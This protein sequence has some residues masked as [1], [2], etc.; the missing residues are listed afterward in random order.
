MPLPTL[1][2]PGFIVPKKNA[3]DNDKKK[4]RNTTGIDHLMSFFSKRIP[5]FKG[6]LPEI[7]ALCAADKVL[8]LKSG[9][10][11]GKST[12]FVEALYD[13]FFDIMK[14]GI[15]I[16]QPRILTAKDIPFTIV[17]RRKD[18]Q[19]GVNIGFQTGI[20]SI[21]VTKGIIFMT[22]Q[23]LVQQLKT[24]TDE[25]FMNKY[26]V[27]IIDEVHTRDTSI[28][29]VMLFMKKLLMRNYNKSECPIL[30][31]MSAT[32]DPSTYFRY[33]GV[34]LSEYETTH[35]LIEVEGLSHPIEEHWL[36]AD[37]DDYI[38]FASDTAL[39]IHT[40]N[41]A[42]LNDD[43][44]GN[45][46]PMRD[47]L[48][49]AANKSIITKIIIELDKYNKSID[50]TT[51]KE[52]TLSPKGGGNGTLFR[53]IPL[54]PADELYSGTD[55]WS[56]EEVIGAD[57]VTKVTKK[58]YWIIP[59]ILTSAEFK[60]G[61]REYLNLFSPISEIRMKS[62]NGET[63]IPT[64]R[65]IVS[66]N[67]A[68]TGVTIETLKYVIISGWSLTSSFVSHIGM[69]MLGANPITQSETK[70]Q[71]GR[72]GRLAPGHVYYAFTKD[73]Y[74][75]M[76]DLLYPAIIR[77]EPTLSLSDIIIAQTGA[78]IK[79]A[80]MV[81]SEKLR[82]IG[83]LTIYP[84]DAVCQV[85]YFDI[86]HA[87]LLD[88]PS[89]D[90]LIYSLEKLHILGFIDHNNNTTMTGLLASAFRK[91]KIENIKMILSGYHYG[92][93]IMDLI[94]ITAFLELKT[95]D[96]HILKRKTYVPQNIFIGGGQTPEEKKQ[97]KKTY[98]YNKLLIQ[99][100]CI[101]FIFIWDAFLQVIGEFSLKD[102]SEENSKEKPM[103]I[104]GDALPP[105]LKIAKWCN[106]SNLN[107]GN[108]LNVAEKIDEIREN[109]INAGLNPFI[110]GIGLPM[111]EYNLRKIITGNISDGVSEISKIKNCIYEGYKLNMCTWNTFINQYMLN[112]KH[113]PIEIDNPLIKLLPAEGHIK[114]L[115]PKKI[116]V[117]DLI[118]KSDPMAGGKYLFQ[119]TGA[120]SVMDGFVS[121]DNGFM[122]AD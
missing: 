36:D 79:Y 67:I 60:K 45:A 33:F 19:L 39:K 72:V 41:L 76:D 114:Q 105:S 52:N 74:N 58:K 81:T 57:E 96:S 50:G 66:T 2:K 86:K 47:I 64:R 59:I 90:N 21:R 100:D 51:K 120:I 7:E 6:A 55:Y 84:P 31:L 95:P 8:I 112:H 12:A 75:R 42:E 119:S 56:D 118:C 14:K 49:F 103:G 3:T 113:I 18:Y 69:T 102:K 38:K 30:V 44:E 121:I 109:C 35:N 107:Y 116:I 87:D 80:E 10:G 28:D 101:E 91:N 85:E 46:N 13:I 20:V 32:L 27:I 23:V 77:S 29:L 104:T 65:I 83:K 48:I 110:N 4:L 34:P 37:V 99:D 11:S 106:D 17:K 62:P 98:L 73:S 40:E 115:N 82:E 25:E 78:E 24:L 63:V 61:D 93:N 94:V 71:K 97:S 1:L 54:I 43:D 68:E 89:A 70:Q 26:F 5:Q 92:C 16:T 15:A 88:Y 9:T 108:L 117:T 122:D 22:T 111:G 53:K